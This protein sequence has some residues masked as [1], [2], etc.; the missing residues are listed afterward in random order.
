LRSDRGTDFQT[1]GRS[2]PYLRSMPVQTE[3]HRFSAPFIPI[4]TWLQLSPHDLP[5]VSTRIHLPNKEFEKIE[6]AWQ[7]NIFSH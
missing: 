3:I 5:T 2:H 1:G 4:I 7:A 6:I